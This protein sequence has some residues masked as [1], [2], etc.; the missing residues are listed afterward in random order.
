MR[1]AGGV[2][3]LRP[4][5]V[6]GESAVASEF[7]QGLAA[8]DAVRVR[9][10]ETLGTLLSLVRRLGLFAEEAGGPVG[11]LATPGD[12]GT[13]NGTNVVVGLTEPDL[14]QGDHVLSLLSIPHVS[15]GRRPLGNCGRR[16]RTTGF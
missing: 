11:N 16:R 3:R 4:P 1:R 15:V 10:L 14:G 2:L 5:A 7:G 12:Q 9:P 6:H 8:G 13:L